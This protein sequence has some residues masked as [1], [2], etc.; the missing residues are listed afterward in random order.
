MSYRD[1]NEEDDMDESDRRS[2]GV[3]GNGGSCA[4]RLCVLLARVLPV[5]RE[6]VLVC[7]PGLGS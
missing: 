5:V 2:K 4:G 7:I 1:D 3:R 6:E